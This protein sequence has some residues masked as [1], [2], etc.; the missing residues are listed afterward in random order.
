MFDYM[1]TIIDLYV[2]AAAETEELEGQGMVEYGLLLALISI[3]AI[4]VLVLF[5][6]E[7]V[8]IF[9]EALDGLQ[10]R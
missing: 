9:Q 2:P 1:K 7:L 8:N 10:S 5:G 4:A 6:P 3:A